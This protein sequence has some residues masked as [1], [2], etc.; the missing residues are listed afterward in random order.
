[1]YIIVDDFLPNF[2]LYSNML[3]GNNG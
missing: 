3:K 2:T 1:M